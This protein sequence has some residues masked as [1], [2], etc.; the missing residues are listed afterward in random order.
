MQLGVTAEKLQEFGV[1]TLAIVA[2]QAERARLYFRMRPTRYPLGADPDLS[3]HRAYGV[4]QSPVTPEIMQVVGSAYGNLAREL[5][6]KV[7]EAETMQAVDRADGFQPTESE[8][9]IQQQL[10]QHTGQF[11]VDRNGIIRWA[12]IECAKEGLAGLTKF[13][14]DEELLAAARALPT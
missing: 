4:P 13:P 3:T 10:G 11:L 1:Q 12:N 6:L 8:A 2:T 9:E 14:T 5:Q 7:P